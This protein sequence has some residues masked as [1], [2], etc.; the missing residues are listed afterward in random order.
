MNRPISRLLFAFVLAVVLLSAGFFL[1]GRGSQQGAFTLDLVPPGF[2]QTAHAEADATLAGIMDEAGI[3]GYYQTDGAITITPALRDVFRTVESETSTYIVGSVPVPS[4]PE[5]YDV[6]VYVHTDGWIMIYYLDTDPVGKII[7]WNVY[8]S[9]APSIVT[10]FESV[11][12]IVAGAAGKPYNSLN[13]YDFRYP[14]ANQMT[15]IAEDNAAEDDFIVQLPS[16]YTYFEYS[17][18][19]YSITN[20]D[21]EWR[22]DDARIN[23]SSGWRA[24]LISAGLMLPNVDHTVEI[25]SFHYCEGGLALVYRV[26]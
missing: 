8:T 7:D 18:S 9:S 2:V 23:Y 5:S 17:W 13:Y 3:A 20:A 15:L 1:R 14:N 26:P 12:P 16:S 4:T 10:V 11:A 21:C 24:G 19:A 25:D 22:L 6:H